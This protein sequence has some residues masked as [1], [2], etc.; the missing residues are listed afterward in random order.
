MRHVER[1][2]APAAGVF[3][4]DCV[5]RRNK[6]S[7]HGGKPP[8]WLMLCMV[9]KKRTFANLWLRTGT[10]RWQTA[11][12]DPMATWNEEEEVQL[13]CRNILTSFGDGIRSSNSADYLQSRNTGPKVRVQSRSGLNRE[14][15]CI[16]RTQEMKTHTERC[17]YLHQRRNTSKTANHP[18]GYVLKNQPLQDFERLVVMKNKNLETFYGMRRP[19]DLRCWRLTVMWSEEEEAAEGVGECWWFL[20]AVAV[21]EDVML[22]LTLWCWA[23]SQ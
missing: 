2:K 13:R 14:R 18:F 17:W 12:C 9:C 10:K 6:K 21:L 8:D 20:F 11:A 7:I 22:F 15:R 5:M 4:L 19:T 23:A 1:E 3:D 16:H